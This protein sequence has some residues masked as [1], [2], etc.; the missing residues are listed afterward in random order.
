MPHCYARKIIMSAEQGDF[1]S[2]MIQLLESKNPE[3]IMPLSSVYGNSK[4][5]IDLSKFFST[6]VIHELGHTYHQQYPFQFP[7]LWLMELF[8]NLCNYICLREIN[9][10][11]IIY[12]E[13]FPKYLSQIDKAEYKFNTWN[14]FE[15]KYDIIPPE[16]YGWYQSRLKEIAIR[17]YE[18]YGENILIKIWNTFAQS[19]AD[20]NSFISN[21][22]SVELVEL[23]SE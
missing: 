20:L 19:N 2:N 7:R 9:S 18:I 13:T 8:A 3:S 14:D 10:E 5:E 11:L 15:E 17:L 16:N 21:K 12:L 22:I 1:W 6:L 23:L 4:G